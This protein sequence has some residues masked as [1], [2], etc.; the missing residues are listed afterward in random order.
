MRPRAPHHDA[1]PF[2]RCDPRGDEGVI[3]A[4]D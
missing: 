1:Q 3:A 4:L 2:H